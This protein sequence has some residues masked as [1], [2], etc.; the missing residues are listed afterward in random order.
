MGYKNNV[1]KINDNRTNGAIAAERGTFAYP[2]ADKP[3]VKNTVSV[4]VSDIEKG[5]ES[6][7]DAKCNEIASDFDKLMESLKKIALKRFVKMK[8]QPVWYDKEVAGVYA[9]KFGEFNTSDFNYYVSGLTKDWRGWHIE[10]T[11]LTFS[12]PQYDEVVKSFSKGIK[13]PLFENKE[14]MVVN[15]Q[16]YNF[17]VCFKGNGSA[18]TTFA[19]RENMS[20]RGSYSTQHVMI[21]TLCRFGEKNSRAFTE[22]ESVKA[23][24]DH[25]LIPDGLTYGENK[26]YQEWLKHYEIL[27]NYILPDKNGELKFDAKRFKKDVFSG[28]FVQIVFG[29][30]FD[31]KVRKENIRTGKEKL[32]DFSYFKDMLLKVDYL[33]ANISPYADKQVS[34]INVGHW[35]LFEPEGKKENYLT[36]AV[37]ACERIIAR[38]PQLDVVEGGV[39]GIDFGTK[40][41]VVAC[42][43][44]EAVLLRVGKGDYEKEATVTDYENPTVIQLRDFEAFMQAYTEKNGRPDTRWE[45]MTVS[46]QAA[47]A[48]FTDKN[49]SEI[50]YTVFSELKQWANDKNRRLLLKDL[51]NNTIEVKPYLELKDGDF[52]PIEIYAYYLGQYINNMYNKIYLD[53]ILSFPVNYSKEVR[54]HLL[55][56]FEKGLRKSLP[57]AILEDSDLME[58]FRVYAG[59]SEPAAYAISALQENGLEPKT[60]EQ[61]VCYGVF[62]FGGGTTDFD[63]GIMSVP[64][65]RRKNRFLIE[66]FGNGGDVYLG[67]ENIL[68]LLAY[69]VYKKNVAIMRTNNIPFVLPPQ[70]KSFAGAER[71]VY[72][73]KSASQQAYLNCKRLAKE[74][75]PL[76]E[77]HENYQQNYANNQLSI[78]LFTNNAQDKKNTVSVTL[79]ID[80]PVLEKCI[81]ERI[82]T[83]VENF[84]TMLKV[85]FKNSTQLQMPIH[86]FLAGNSSKHPYVAELFNAHIKKEETAFAKN[87]QRKTGIAK[88]G[89]GCFKLY[90]PL[91]MQ[92]ST[93]GKNSTTAPVGTTKTQT[94]KSNNSANNSEILKLKESLKEVD[95][96]YNLART[97]GDWAI[98]AE[99][100]VVRQAIVER[101]KALGGNIDEKAEV[102]RN[103][104]TAAVSAASTKTKTVSIKGNLG[105]SVGV[106]FDK[107]H[108]G[109]T[110]VVFGLLRSRKGGKD[111]K[112]INLND[113]AD[114]E[115][116][117]PFFLGDIDENGRFHVVIGQGVDYN[118]WTEFTYA[119]EEDFELSYTTEPKALQGVL[120]ESEVK[121]LHCRIKPKEVKDDD[122]V[123]IFVRKVAP[124]KIEYAVGKKE[125]FAKGFTGTP[126]T[127]MLTR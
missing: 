24:L 77:Q 112:I 22:A 114:G 125:D 101:I 52:D 86:I 56:S 53:Y 50:Y 105:A 7:V 35:D 82:E 96:D 61:K 44:Q 39:V 98:E 124:D 121:T 90:M 95:V 17:I 89:S 94:Q 13:S 45:Q 67:G 41:T 64:E 25:K 122:N 1:N 70:A 9:D 33:R 68:D 54:E 106:D 26:Y 76:W 59:A 108:T 79:N 97:A 11:D 116:K 21:I 57:T 55:H 110:G 80:I 40:S 75:R 78:E 37:P 62:D 85:A 123:K 126:Y 2:A 27:G 104:K 72:D 38:P 16:G 81:K 115:T 4:R 127:K 18:Y 118:I 87:L 42:R 111:V 99:I 103:V 74:L 66:Q 12:L 107:L 117:F 113:S 47:E 34:D 63:F 84:F 29:F 83:G 58:Y 30:D 92:K 51:K 73:R 8:N 23:W 102:T 6:M 36:I 48:I 15:G 46:H 28:S 3:F 120:K 49:N 69:E 43:Q 60:V 109:K 10:G 65:N 93:T 88:D 32:Q 31:V 71:L 14:T 119:D 100:A 5:L 20:E 91:G 19:N